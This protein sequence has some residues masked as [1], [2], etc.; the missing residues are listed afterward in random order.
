MLSREFDVHDPVLLDRIFNALRGASCPDLAAGVVASAASCLA[1]LAPALP[2]PSLERLL[3]FVDPILSANVADDVVDAYTECLARAAERIPEV[4]LSRVGPGG[5]DRPRL[6]SRLGAVDA[7]LRCAIRPC[8][9]PAVQQRLHDDSEL[10]ATLARAMATASSATILEAVDCIAMRLA[11]GDAYSNDIVDLFQAIASRAPVDVQTDLCKVHV[12]DFIVSRRVTALLGA[13]L[14]SCRV[15]PDPDRL[16]AGL[17]EDSSDHPDLVGAVVNNTDRTVDDVN[18]RDDLTRVWV[19]KALAMRGCPTGIAQC[20]DL[21]RERCAHFPVVF[22]VDPKWHWR[23]LPLYKQRVLH[24][25]LPI[26]LEQLEAGDDVSAVL[27]AVLEQVPRPVI[28][29]NTAALLPV[30]LRAFTK[31]D[32][33]VAL[34]A[35]TFATIS[36]L[37]ASDVS[38]IASD[39]S[40]VIGPLLRL[41]AASSRDARAS[42]RVAAL[43][44]L[45]EFATLPH[46]VTYPF[47]SDIRAALMKAMD[48]P[49]RVVRQAARRARQVWTVQ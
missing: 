20:R 6:L 34:L 30:L 46:H 44:T 27:A 47:A 31:K 49:K 3:D 29:E 25:V 8:L 22:Q 21:V 15:I 36:V 11:P 5:L 24:A 4:V 40:A 23:V 45:I 33:T 42:V 39:F 17:L 14:H 26:F 41:A 32:A 9:A 19:A 18:A 38:C 48:D 16:L 35:S 37:I 1:R 43:E 7:F 12:D 13:C 10:I 28:L 2:L